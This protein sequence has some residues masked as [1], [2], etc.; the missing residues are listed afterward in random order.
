MA[1]DPTMTPN[2][3]HPRLLLV[4]DEPEMRKMMA[5]L[6]TAAGYAVE[7]A[8]DGE[9][10]LDRGNKYDLIILD[11]LLPG[12]SGL[13]ICGEL[14]RN[15]VTAGILIVSGRAEVMDR[16]NGLRQGA[17]DYL[18]KP[19]SPPELLARIEALLRRLRAPA[20]GVPPVVQVGD[21]KV[22][23]TRRTVC[24]ADGVFVLP[25][26]EGQLLR[27][28]VEHR[29]KVVSRAQMLRDVWGYHSA[30]SSRTVDVHIAR[31]RQKL[32]SWP[33]APRMLLTIRGGGY[34]LVF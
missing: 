31:L 11:V 12:K 3:I 15:G 20:N 33:D 21:A 30:A 18:I 16:V 22:D 19:F 27:Y 28:L 8:A 34:S 2:S 1:S 5:A 23:F 17:D 10:A 24:K 32:E 13:E 6:L 7:T 9:T 25:P 4:D 29:R 14:R 26:K